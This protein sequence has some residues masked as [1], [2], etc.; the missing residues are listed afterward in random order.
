MDAAI[1]GSVVLIFL[2]LYKKLRFEKLNFKFNVY[3]FLLVPVVAAF[4]A[5][6]YH[7]QPLGLSLYIIRANFIWLLYFVLH[8]LNIPKKQLINLLL[9]VGGTW[10]FLTIVQQFTYPHFYFYTREGD[11]DSESFYRA[12]IYRFFLYRH[13]YGLFFIFYFFQQY[14]N[15]Q[16]VK[17][18]IY[19][20]IGLLGLYYFGSRQVLAAGM[21]C[22]AIAVVFARGKSKL[23]AIALGLCG[24]T[25]LLFLK[26]S[27][28]GQYVAMTQSQIQNQ[29]TDVRMITAKF[30]LYDY[31]PSWVCKIIGNGRPSFDSSYGQEIDALR[32]LHFFRSDVGLIGGYNEFGIFYVINVLWFN[33]RGVVGNFYDRNNLYLKLFF[34]NALML[35]LFSEFY[36]DP[37]SIPFYCFIMYLIDKTS[38]EKKWGTEDVA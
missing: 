19:V 2:F 3:L 34:Y 24:L 35:V 16:R 37:A 25:V 31:W 20:L 27:L 26:D 17:N 23:N 5:D 4:G 18:L 32:E 21:V 33:I 28:F 7:H 15:T 36:S 22:L 13:H 6:I 9:F 11:S 1:L 29:D 10:I 30:F 8:I 14:L 38:E 12:G